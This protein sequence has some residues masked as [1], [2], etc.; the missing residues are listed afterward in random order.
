MKK[1][2][3]LISF[4]LF[5]S[6]LNTEFLSAQTGKSDYD[7][8][9]EQQDNEFKKYQEKNRK[10]YDDYRA[11]VNAEYAEYMRKTWES[12]SS[13]RAIP[14]PKAPEPATQP[15]VEPE[16]KP[17]AEQ[18]P[19]AKVTPVPVILP[20]PQP[21]TSGEPA[22]SEP[23]KTEQPNQEKP[24]TPK[25]DIVKQQQT[26]SEKPAFSFLFFNTEC[27]VTLNDALRFS[28]PDVSEQNVA[29]TWKKLS[30]SQ[31]NA[32]LNECLALRDKLNLSDWGYFQLLKSM[33]EKF[34]GKTSNEAV[35]L[36]MYILTQ[37][38]Y[39]VRIAKAG[40]RLVLLIPFNETIYEYSYLNIG[41]I[42]Y[43]ITN[44]ELQGSSYSMCNQEFPKEQFFSWQTKQPKLTEK[45]NSPKTFTSKAVPGI[46]LSIKT[47]QSLIDY[48]NS[49]PLSSQ[50]NLYTLTGLSETVKK[51]LYPELQRAIAGKTKPQAADVLLHFLQTT[52]AYQTDDQQFGYERPFFADENFFYP[53]NNCKDRAILYCLL[54]KELLGLESVLLEYPQHL[55]TAVYFQENVNGDFI[56]INN[57]KF[58]I[59][60]PTYIGA[61][62]GMAMPD[63]KKVS[64]NV[65]KIW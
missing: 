27:N 57:K 9:K 21:V 64:A 15:K 13:Q 42:K 1:L 63:C 25:N 50:W 58:I 38:G 45:L 44:R 17:T 49:Y 23:E 40:S 36:Q 12:F 11:K 60:D 47:N 22:A 28:L 59:C 46:N 52:F 53:A 8:W 18:L 34:L 32:M 54:V 20:S 31:Y 5:C 56:T 35:L 14:A 30:T 24:Q 43:Y 61:N 29:N 39:K 33:S 10:E 19:V 55:A 16:A 2:T 7:K 62:I 4:L 65:V 51:V 3:I 41:G 37:S 48:Y 26:P 6:S